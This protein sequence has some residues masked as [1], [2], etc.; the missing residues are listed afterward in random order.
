[1]CLVAAVTESRSAI[2]PADRQ[3]IGRSRQRPVIDKSTLGGN[4]V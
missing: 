1:M 4:F 3:Q 2:L